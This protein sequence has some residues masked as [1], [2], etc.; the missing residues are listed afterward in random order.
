MRKYSFILLIVMIVSLCC[1]CFP[2]NSTATLIVDSANNPGVVFD[3]T[4]D[5]YWVQ[6]L[7]ESANTTYSGILLLIS[8]WNSAGTWSSTQYGPWQLASYDDMV[9]LWGYSLEDISTNFNPTMTSSETIY[10]S[11]RYEN[12]ASS[13]GSARHY[14]AG[15]YLPS[16]SSTSSSQKISLEILSIQDTSDYFMTGGWVVAHAAKP[17]PEPAT[18]MLFGLGLLGLAG[19]SRRKK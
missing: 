7:N 10:Y 4:N 13:T 3:D 2:R 9:K 5:L 11:G 1:M 18:M 15:V 16:G 12:V 19:V 17:I 6:D 8:S 14:L